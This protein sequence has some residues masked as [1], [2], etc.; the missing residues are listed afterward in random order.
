MLKTPTRIVAIDFGLARLGVA[1]SDQSK[2]IASPMTTIKA[3][4]RTQDTVLKFLEA[5]SNYQLEGKYEIEEIVIGL[6]LLMSGKKGLLADEVQH[7]VNEL[8]L[9][10]NI[11]VTLWD[12]RLTSVQADR[13][14]RE[15]NFSRKKRAQRVD[16]VAATLILQNYLDFRH[17]KYSDLTL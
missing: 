3:E 17:I 13:V 10:T 14:L 1:M 5:L 9:V 15:S 2:L 6:P 7:F 4:K 11:P 16:A 12:E 8:K